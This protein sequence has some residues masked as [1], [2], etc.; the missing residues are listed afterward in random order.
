MFKDYIELA[1]FCANAVHL[2]RNRRVDPY[3]DGFYRFRT[4]QDE[5]DYFV[6]LVQKQYPDMNILIGK[7]LC[8]HGVMFVPMDSGDCGFIVST[9]CLT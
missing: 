5:I 6:T 4:S 2:L 7:R 9:D 3:P 1:M 8:V